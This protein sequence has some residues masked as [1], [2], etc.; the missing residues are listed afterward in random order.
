MYELKNSNFGAFQIFN[1]Q[2]RDAQPTEGNDAETKAENVFNGEV[3]NI[4]ISIE[5]SK[6]T[7]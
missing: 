6:S 4:F 5:S 3:G 1:F 2:V 7:A